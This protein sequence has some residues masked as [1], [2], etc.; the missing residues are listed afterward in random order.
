MIIVLG[1]VTVREG[2]L[3]QALALSQEHV[4]RFR[5]CTDCVGGRTS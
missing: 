5:Q 1:N 2:K 3:P 4:A